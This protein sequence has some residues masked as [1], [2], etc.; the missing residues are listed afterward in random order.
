MILNKMKS[1]LQMTLD[2]VLSLNLVKWLFIWLTVKVIVKNNYLKTLLLP[3]IILAMELLVYVDTFLLQVINMQFSTDPLEKEFGK[4][5]QGKYTN[6][7]DRRKL[8]VLSDH[9]CQ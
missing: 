9:T 1:N 2:L 3:Y 6:R 7:T 8:K 5:R 4:L